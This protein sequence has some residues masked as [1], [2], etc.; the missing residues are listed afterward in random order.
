MSGAFG[1]L[2]EDLRAFAER[3]SAEPTPGLVFRMAAIERNLAAAL[4]LTGGPARLRPH[5]KTHRSAELVRRCLARGITSFKVATLPEAEMVATA[6]GKD[7]LVAYPCTGPTAARLGVF[8]ARHPGVR[9]GVL[10]DDPA[11]LP[12]LAASGAALDVWI[13]LDTG[14]GRTGVPAGEGALDLARAVDRFATLRLAGLH[15]YD[16]HR[17]ESEFRA[18]KAALESELV[19]VV[20]LRSALGRPDLPIAGGGTPGF[21]AWA[22]LEIPGVVATPGIFVLHD[23]RSTL[24]FPDLPFEVAAVVAARV[25]S[26]RGERMTLDLGSK[27]VCPDQPAGERALLFGVPEAREG[28]LSEE[29]WVWTR[30]GGAL[31]L[32]ARVFVVPAHVCPTV[33]NFRDALGIDDDGEILGRYEILSSRTLRVDCGC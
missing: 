28:P 21:T 18:R 7:I 11:A 2:P 17:A 24:R 27:S 32:G 22:S 14:M 13:D 25:T 4:A 19:P 9:F 8:A 1:R 16:G 29:H 12:E 10:A 31:P 6:G 3:H 5:V 15:V 30:P 26:R 33:A 23:A 20:A